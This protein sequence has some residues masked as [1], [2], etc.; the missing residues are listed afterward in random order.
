[1]ALAEDSVAAAVARAMG[2]AVYEAL[3][4]QLLSQAKLVV[5]YT[6]CSLQKTFVNSH[7][8]SGLGLTADCLTDTCKKLCE[9]T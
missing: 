7:W 6:Q 8:L 2:A 4:V 5:D 1:M 9:I 3:E